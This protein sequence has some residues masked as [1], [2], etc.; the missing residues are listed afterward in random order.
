MRDTNVHG[1]EQ[2]SVIQRSRPQR[3]RIL[4]ICWTARIPLLGAK[5]RL[6]GGQRR[7]GWARAPRSFFNF[8]PPGAWAGPGFSKQAS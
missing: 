8:F 5:C 2:R 3:M 4:Y 7:D 6:P 1:D